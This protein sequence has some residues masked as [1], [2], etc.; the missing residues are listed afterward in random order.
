LYIVVRIPFCIAVIAQ[1]Q[2]VPGMG[3]SVI[4]QAT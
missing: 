2:L 4:S 3:Y 1:Y